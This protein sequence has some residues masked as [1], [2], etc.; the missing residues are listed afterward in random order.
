[1]M[2][3]KSIYIIFSNGML[4]YQNIITKCIAIYITKSIRCIDTDKDTGKENNV[5][6]LS[7]M[8]IIPPNAN[9][10]KQQN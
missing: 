10:I 2:L 7:E 9:Q 6:F 1:M 5:Y 8:K 4:K 3:F